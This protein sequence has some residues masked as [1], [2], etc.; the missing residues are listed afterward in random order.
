M[1]GA[2][3]VVAGVAAELAPPNVAFGSCKLVLMAARIVE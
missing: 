2:K 3:E 1:P